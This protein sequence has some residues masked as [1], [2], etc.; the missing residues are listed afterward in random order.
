MF[1]FLYLIFLEPISSSVPLL[2]LKVPNQL[3]QSVSIETIPKIV[4]R[5]FVIQFFFS[6]PLKFYFLYYFFL[7]FL[8]LKRLIFLKRYKRRQQHTSSKSKVVL[9]SMKEGKKKIVHFEL[10]WC[11]CWCLS[12]I[13]VLPHRYSLRENNQRQII[14][15]FFRADVY[16]IESAGCVVELELYSVIDYIIRFYSLIH[17]NL[18]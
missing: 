6:P 18:P 1:D 17:T 12:S 7:L 10:C 13:S 8:F 14:K 15:R 11:W 4:L 3:N 9:P 2:A 5:D 16:R